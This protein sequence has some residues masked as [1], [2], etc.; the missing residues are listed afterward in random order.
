MHLLHAHTSTTTSV[1]ENNFVTSVLRILLTNP[2]SQSNKFV[3]CSTIVDS[4]LLKPS[5]KKTLIP[6]GDTSSWSLPFASIIA[7]F[8][9]LSIRWIP[10]YSIH[11]R[12]IWQYSS[13]HCQGYTHQA[14]P[15]GSWGLTFAP[16]QLEI[17][18]WA[19][20]ISQVQST[21]LLSVFLRAEPWLSFRVITR[22]IE[23]FMN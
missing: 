5:G 1:S 7:I 14:A 9:W 20:W 6:K 17:I 23:S 18:Y 8:V 3:W 19:P 11:F 16:G 21:G 15:S 13:K 22:D 10:L 2:L 4:P 12:E